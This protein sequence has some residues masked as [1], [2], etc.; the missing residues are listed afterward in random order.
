MH[1]VSPE[2]AAEL[3]Q[4]FFTST[5]QACPNYL[6]YKEQDVQILST[7]P[8]GTERLVE[9]KSLKSGVMLTAAA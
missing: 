9:S 2:L 7:T 1:S 5:G 3:V 6:S 8:C 4:V